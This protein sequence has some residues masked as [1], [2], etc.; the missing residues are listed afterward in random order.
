[1]WGIALSRTKAW[2]SAAWLICAVV[3]VTWSS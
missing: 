3:N 2:F 1:M